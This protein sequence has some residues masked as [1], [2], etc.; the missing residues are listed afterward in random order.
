MEDPIKII[1]KVKNNNRKNQYHIYIFLGNLVDSTIQ[2]ILKKFKDLNLFETLTNL[3]EKERDELEKKYGIKWYTYFFVHHHIDFTFDTIRKSKQKAEE[4]IDKISREWYDFHIKDYKISGKT[5]FNYSSIVSR[6]RMNKF[7]K[8]IV[9]DDKFDYRTNL[10]KQLGGDI[11]DIDNISNSISDNQ[12]IGGSK[13]SSKK[14]SKKGVVKDGEYL[15]MIDNEYKMKKYMNRSFVEFLKLSEDKQSGGINPDDIAEESDSESDDDIINKINAPENVQSEQDEAHITEEMSLEELE[16]IYSTEDKL[17]LVIENEKDTKKTSELIEK[18]LEQDKDFDKIEK[19]N[20]L[21]SFDNSKDNTN[22]DESLKNVFN[23]QYVFNNYIYKNDTIKNIKNKITC[24]IKKNKMFDKNSELLIPSRVYLWS[25]YYYNELV[26]NRILVKYDKIM[27][28]QKWVRRNELL[29]IDI[30]PND[31]IKVYESLRNNLRILRDNIK[32]YGSNIR[33]ENDQ[34]NVLDDYNDYFTNNEIF[35]CDIYNELGRN[36]ATD[37]ESLKNLYDVYIR[38]YF[39]SISSDEFKNIMDYLNDSKKDEVELIT[40]TYNNITND[41]KMENTITRIIEEIKLKPELYKHYLKTNHITQVVTHINLFMTRYNNKTINIE[42]A[43]I[44]KSDNKIDLFRI[45]DNF[46]T[47]DIYPF[48]QFQQGDGNLVYKFN[49]DNPEQDKNAILS[50]WFETAPYGISFKIKV[51]L[52]KSA[53]N[54][55]ISVNMNDNGRVEYKI[56]FKEEDVASFDDI[57]NTY[58]FVKDLIKK[59][60]DENTRLQL[61]IPNDKDFKFAFI[62][63]IQQIETKSV[64]NHNDLDDFA[65]LFYPYVAVVINPRKRQA[66]EKIETDDQFGKYGTYLRYKRVS[67]YESDRSLEKRILYFLRNFEFDEKKMI[68]EISNSFNLTDKVSEQKIKDIRDKFPYLK[69]AG[70][71]LRKFDN[72]PRFKAPGIDV[73]LQG[74]SKENYKL[75]IS[76]SRNKHQ[77]ESIC[78]FISIMIYLYEDIYVKKNPERKYLL[79]ILKGLN[80]IAKRR[81]KVEEI[82]ETEDK[83]VSKVKEITK[84][85]KERLG[86]KPEKGQSQWTR[87]CQNSGKIKRRPNVNTTKTINE[88]VKNGYKLNDKTNIY[89]KKVVTKISGKNKEIILK[90]A[91]VSS[92]K[93]EDD[94]YFTCDPT[95]NGKFMYVGFLTKSN[96]PSGLC[97][98]CCFIKDP[99]DSNNKAKKIFNQ[100]CIGMGETNSQVVTDKSAES[101]VTDKVY[102]LQDTNKLQE[103][104]YAFLPKYLDIFFNVINKNSKTIKNNY[105]TLSET[106]YFFKQGVKQEAPYISSIAACLNISVDDLKN[107]LVKALESDKKLKLF[108]SLNKGDIRSQFNSINEYINFIKTNNSLDYELLDDLICTKDILTKNGLNIFIFMKQAKFIIKDD[109]KIEKDD[110]I[111]ICKNIENNIHFQE[112]DTILLIKETNQYFPIFFLKKGIKDTIIQIQKTYNSSMNVVKSIIEYS[113]QNCTDIINK[114]LSLTAKFIYMKNKTNI[115]GQIIDSKFRCKYLLSKNNIL[116]PCTSSGS[117]SELDLYYDDDVAKY[118]NDLDTT[119]DAIYS[120]L[121]IYPSGLFYSNKDKDSDSVYLVDGLMFS[122]QINIPI[123]DIKMTKEDIK[124]FGKKI[125]LKDVSIERRN[126]YDKIDKVLKDGLDEINKKGIIDVN[127]DTYKN[128]GFKQFK[129]ELSNFII[130]DDELINKLTDTY[131]SKKSYEDKSFAIKKLFFKI[132]N[133][134][135]IKILNK[136]KDIKDDLDGVEDNG[137]ESETEFSDND[138]ENM[139]GGGPMMGPNI[140]LGGSKI[141]KYSTLKGGDLVHTVKKIPELNDYATKNIIETCELNNND[142]KCITNKLCT[143]KNNECKMGLTKDYII[144]YVNKLTDEILANEYKFFELINK[145]KYS[146]TD[147]NDFYNFTNRPK[148]KIIKSNSVNVDKILSEI[149]GEDNIPILGKKRF[150]K[151]EDNIIEHPPEEYKDKIIQLVD[152][153]EGIYRAITNSFYWH[154]N[155]ML[156]NDVRN[157]GYYSNLQ[158]DINNYIKSLLIDYLRNESNRSE[159]IEYFSSLNIDIKKDIYDYKDKIIKNMDIYDEFI[160]ELYIINKLLNIPIIIYNDYE[161][162]IALYDDGIKFHKKYNIGTEKGIDKYTNIK[163]YMNIKL[164]FAMK[165]LISNFRVIYYK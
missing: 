79:D 147:V 119:V 3:N 157:L 106:G 112:R 76:G 28:G 70:R 36:Y 90:A 59:I 142:K 117:I 109:K 4:I 83:T 128:D 38:I 161:N 162:I 145:D 163:N 37:N 56:Q 71:V 34:Y 78:E 138:G 14:S 35:L 114:D 151:I 19:L 150:K 152:F 57:K 62:N 154:E 63:T 55:Y 80:N 69:K 132:V 11:N 164:E 13:K 113:N 43:N 102:I 116:L 88:L 118:I 29:Q 41:I 144:T 68:R 7:T 115:N 1:Y 108:T 21:I 30:E 15:N 61:Y 23:K 134:D 97:M 91:K 125:G 100:K 135:L 26:D 73:N 52:G 72:I 60:N 86:F 58:Q 94:L 22:Y 105:L 165:N 75:R 104:R 133:K 6:D 16:N 50:K 126:Q 84:L 5:S 49:S 130:Q 98:P 33:V 96:N 24:S 89:E 120:I 110:Y 44:K 82:V 140:F 9:D 12:I 141:N 139:Q 131:Y 45:F 40:K 47:T 111:L 127:V 123:K 143:W 156:D 77:L 32:K 54:K 146:V 107:K 148:Q 65:R 8:T 121:K 122:R 103:H 64:I 48:I 67:N 10:N 81:N 85:D 92:S 153:N 160:V 53:T 74:K 46:T 159:I 149:Y 17:D 158:T 93:G 99:F 95:D 137:N 2:K 66:K 25:E 39:L 18:I 129:L 51:N 124:K 20:E 155:N 136:L 31:N 87:S 27:L 42:N 101:V